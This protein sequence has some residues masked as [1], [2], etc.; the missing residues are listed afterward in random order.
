MLKKHTNLP[1]FTILELLIVIALII[2]L[3]KLMLPR[4]HTLYAKARQTEV[5]LNLSTL[6]AAQQAFQL[7]QGRFA[8]T[9][10]ELD[11]QPKGYTGNPATTH[12]A[13]TYGCIGEQGQ[14]GALY[15]TGSTQTPP[16]LLSGGFMRPQQFLIKAALASNETIEIWN[17]DHR[18]DITQE[19]R[20]P[21]TKS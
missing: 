18:G 9:F 10:A 11:W 2:F 5:S 17:I 16:S 1:S 3:A 14:E 20:D 21:Q 19:K 7:Q 6:Y 4:Y 15:F 8:T 12:H 13:Y